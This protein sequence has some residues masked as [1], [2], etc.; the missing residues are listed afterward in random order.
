MR[1]LSPAGQQT[2]NDLAQR[3]RAS[4]WDATMSMLEVRESNGNGS[5]AQFNHPEF[6]GSGPV[7]ARRHDD[8]P[9]TCSTTT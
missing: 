5:M 2:I 6:A 8:G 1:Q 4:A 9:P 7:D 3:P